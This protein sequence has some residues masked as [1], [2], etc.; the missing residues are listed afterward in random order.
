MKKRAFLFMVV[1]LILFGFKN[2][3]ISAQDTKL[4][5]SIDSLNSTTGALGIMH[6]AL[7]EQLK[8]LEINSDSLEYYME[9]LNQKLEKMDISFSIPDEIVKQ[10]GKDFER[11]HN[12][13]LIELKG[14]IKTKEIIVNVEKEIPALFFVINGKIEFG[15]SVIEIYDPN[16]KQLGSFKLQNTND[17][18]KQSV[19]NSINKTFK[20]PILG[21][22]KVKVQSEKASGSIV[23]TTIQKL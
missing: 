20:N 12:N 2:E 9:I 17:K 18:N 6:E 11:E 21:E 23:V 4:D 13:T 8:A 19:N 5:S 10:Y 22:W 3:K 15:K 7:M 16:N 14:E 1:T